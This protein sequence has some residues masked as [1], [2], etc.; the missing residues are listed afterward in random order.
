MRIFFLLFLPFLLFGK[1]FKVATYNVENLFD[2]TYNGTEYKEYTSKHHW[3][4]RI[5]NIKL[6]HTAEV[7][8]DLNADILGLQEIENE[9]V[10]RALQQKLDEVGCAYRYAAI[11]RKKGVAV[12][13]GLI[14][15]F[16][17]TSVKEIEVS[18]ASGVR[19]ILEA[20]VEV[21]H[22]PL[23]LFVN[24]WKSRSREGW[25][26]KRMVYARAL[27]KRLKA[28]P[29]GV[30][31]IVLGD[32]NTDYDAA[33][34]LERGINDTEGKTG[35]HHILETTDE[36][37][38]LFKESAL[39]YTL[40][41][42]LELDKRWN[43]K[44]YGR[45]GTPDHILLSHA[46]MD[47]KG[48]NYVDGSFGVFRQN[49]L[50]TKRGYINRWEYKKGNHTGRG[51]SDHLPIYALFD[52][53]PYQQ[54]KAVNALL[55]R[56]VK[57]IEYLYSVEALSREI[58]LEDAVVLWKERGNAL[59]KQSVEGRG[60]F[61]YGCA[62]RLEEGKRYDLLV[63]GIKS[64]NGLKEVTHVYIVKEKASQDLSNYYL[65]QDDL[66]KPQAMRQNEFFKDITGVYREGYFY[67]AGRKIP[68]YFKK[69]KQTPPNG[70]KL[71]I[72]YA[73]LGYYK[74]LQLVVYSPKDFTVMEK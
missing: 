3:T 16:P 7:I 13:V 58:V 9:H 22:Y 37:S 35:L 51:Y 66:Q 45:K 44:F 57:P 26:S 69:R 47:T 32:F 23:H 6:N 27:Q 20:V 54:S 19:N 53:K 68:I 8:C 34:S 43:T 60:I 5:V 63:R 10:L 55:K 4:G 11:T 25:E 40:W 30:E 74:H 2:A 31:Y 28:L 15:R 41:G 12:Q 52:T 56:D 70:A 29:K 61:L 1:P 39:H 73:H 14:S 18:S 42:E 67:T 17:I 24:H 38:R 59:I 33:L 65:T 50:F 72:A 36:R 49:Y 48:V 71:K 46:M 64:Y 21:Q 62:N